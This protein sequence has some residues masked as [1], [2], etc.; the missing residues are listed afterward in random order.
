MTQKFSPSDFQFSRQPFSTQEKLIRA[1]KENFSSSESVDGVNTKKLE[2]LQKYARRFATEMGYVSN[3]NPDKFDREHLLT[4]ALF[5]LTNAQ[6]WI[7][8]QC[9]QLYQANE[10]AINNF[11]KSF[12]VPKSSDSE[13]LLDSIAAKFRIEDSSNIGEELTK[14][15][16]FVPKI[17]TNFG[18]DKRDYDLLFD[19][20]N[21]CSAIRKKCENTSFLDRVIEMLD[22]PSYTSEVKVQQILAKIIKEKD[23]INLL[24][25][26]NYEL[27]EKVNSLKTKSLN[28]SPPKQ[29]YFNFELEETRRKN[30]ELSNANRNLENEIQSLK[31]KII[32]L[33]NKASNTYQIRNNVNNA[34]DLL[35]KQLDNQRKEIEKDSQNTKDL[36]MTIQRQ[37]QLIAQYDRLLGE[38]EQN[39]SP[40]M[41]GKLRKVQSTIVEDRVF[42]I[43]VDTIENA[44]PDLVDGIL[45]IIKSG[46]LTKVDKLKKIILFFIDEVRKQRQS[47]GS[48]KSNKGECQRIITAMHSQLRF[49]ENLVSCDEDIQLLFEQPDDAKKA[50]QDQVTRI[51]QF[52][53]QNAKGFIE[54]A[55]IFDTLQLNADPLELSKRLKSFLD[56]FPKL[57]TPEGEE[58]FVMLRMSLAAN[59]I[60]RRFAIT[61]RNQTEK[62]MNDIHM[63]NNELDKARADRERRTGY[64]LQQINEEVARRE[65]AE[66]NLNKIRL[67]MKSNNGK[68]TPQIMEM[69]E[70]T[71][72]IPTDSDEYRQSLE[73]Q[74]SQALSELSKAK[75]EIE[76]KESPIK[77]ARLQ[78]DLQSQVEKQMQEINRLMKT[79]DSLHNDI[80]HLKE[81][82]ASS[83]VKTDK[84]TKELNNTRE[85]YQTRIRQMKAD[86]NDKISKETEYNTRSEKQKIEQLK[87]TIQK[88]RA[89]RQNLKAVIGE[90]ESKISMLEASIKQLTDD[91]QNQKNSYEKLDALLKETQTKQMS[92]EFQC[93]MLQQKTKNLEERAEKQLALHRMTSETETSAQIDTI[94]T[95]L[96]EKHQNF[97]TQIFSVMRSF[98]NTSRSIDDDNVIEMLKN[99]K[100]TIKE[101]HSK[102]SSLNKQI[103]EVKLIFGLDDKDDLITYAA[104]LKKI[105]DEN[106]QSLK[107]SSSRSTH[108]VRDWEDW[109]RSLYEL[110]IP[111]AISTATMNTVK[112]QIESTIKSASNARKKIEDVIIQRKFIL[113]NELN[114]KDLQNISKLDLLVDFLIRQLPY[115]SGFGSSASPRHTSNDIFPPP[116]SRREQRKLSA[117]LS[118]GYSDEDY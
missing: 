45:K 86:F 7:M 42:D 85:K 81:E 92:S 46:K 59:G 13:T 15:L 105:E 102:K 62:Q 99:V 3:E 93:K 28:N 96:S 20:D 44:P 48:I 14:R 47:V 118:E 16:L 112:D 75:A 107:K 23:T 88:M 56:K 21:L 50:I 24:K 113:S 80:D 29:V 73:K 6:F 84:L 94:R 60:L 104:K 11:A 70:R 90:K 40:L 54:D 117:D 97:L 17:L 8:N 95:E 106:I 30:L 72:D 78:E 57:S 108:I 38:K 114:Q 12:G 67:M 69:L 103:K 61:T 26:Q 36:L 41:I 2:E 27:H 116:Q 71:S 18:L 32:E 1:L 89:N 87:E 31:V 76:A 98:F 109:A 37:G 39:N 25:S 68:N 65:K 100:A 110:F 9:P 115:Q 51:E 82:L 79:I 64:M 74:L 111:R 10:L 77:D 33:E 53:K 63:L 4:Y 66:Y 35:R 91:I 101:L 58:L 5:K 55:N 19:V 52:L 43:I 49:L 22:L 34:V 83:Q